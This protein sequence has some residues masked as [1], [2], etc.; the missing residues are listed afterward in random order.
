[1]KEEGPG[2]GGAEEGSEAAKGRNKGHAVGTA[3]ATGATGTS[4]A[5]RRRP[6]LRATGGAE[7]KEEEAKGNAETCGIEEEGPRAKG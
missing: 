3:G 4:R 7:G 2:A 5:L 1:M 6:K